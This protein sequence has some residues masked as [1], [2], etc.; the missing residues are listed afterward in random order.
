[1]SSEE[2]Q[3]L[4][5]EYAA[6]RISAADKR[7]L[8]AAALEDQELF[9]AIA[10]Q[11]ELSEL[12]VSLPAAPAKR[13]VWPFLMT[14]A[15]TGAA[16]LGLF[17]MMRPQPEPVVEM[18]KAVPP[19][20]VDSAPPREPAVSA[21]APVRKQAPMPIAAPKVAA[22]EPEAKKAEAAEVAT[23]AAAPPPY[24]V[25]RREPEGPPQ[26]VDG[27]ALLVRYRA[28]QAGRFA[29]VDTVSGQELA[30]AT[31]AAGQPVDLPFTAVRGAMNLEIRRVEVALGAARMADR[32]ESRAAAPAAPPAGGAGPRQAPGPLRISLTIR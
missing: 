9:D 19:A 29:L 32:A 22:E 31:A 14:A 21:P 23:F 12:T 25:L 3:L 7:R 6:G 16:A 15:A 17:L 20:V 8:M 28:E 24:Q 11:E 5:G 1:M 26:M 30:A 27:E 2:K 10:E 4:F 18:A 13:K